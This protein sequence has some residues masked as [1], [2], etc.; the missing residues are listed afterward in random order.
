MV[1]VIA[2]EPSGDVLGVRLMGSLK[3]ITDGAVT[4]SGVG[5]EQMADQGL[6]S[7]FPMSELSVMG[8]AE[9]LPHIPNLLRRITETV[10]DIRAKQPAIVVTIDS[11]GFTLRVAAKLKGSGIPVIHYVAPSVWAW[12][13][14]RAKRIAAYL[15]GIMTLLPFEPPYFEKVGLKSYFVGHS[16]LESDAANGDGPAFRDRLGLSNQET[17]LCLLPGSRQG[18]ISRHLPIMKR[19]LDILQSTGTEFECVIP[20]LTSRNTYVAEV[21]KDWPH[22]VHVVTGDEEKYHAI[23]ASDGAIAASGTVALELAMAGLPFVTIYKMNPLSGFL[24]RLIVKTKYVNLVNIILD[25][26][27]VPELL[28]EDCLPHLIA[29]AVRN[30]LSNDLDRLR[31]RNGFSN[32]L[33]RLSAGRVPPSECAAEAVL[34]L[35]RHHAKLDKI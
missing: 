24:A 22:A 1:Y 16:I 19:T 6:T 21:V 14:W 3:K 18:E 35:M 2:G 13:A 28:L 9:V 26:E 11:P 12:K 29:P 10:E 25:E 27:I 8:V 20:T 34:D 4:F 23:A 15:E 33:E 17:L 5:G 7:L 30:C 31:Q 32:A